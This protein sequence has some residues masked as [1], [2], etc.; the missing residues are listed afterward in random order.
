MLFASTTLNYMDRQSMSLVG[1][2]I[3][4]EFRIDNEGFGW[5]LAAFQLTYALFQVPAGYLADRWDVRK[6]YAV[7]VAWWSLA[8]IMVAF[9]STLAALL[10]FRVLLGIGE[11]FNWPCA[12]KVT[13]KVLPPESRSLGNGIFN[14]GAAIGAVITPLIV[15]PLASYFGWRTAFVVAGMLGFLWVLVWP[16]LVYRG[17]IGVFDETPR[18]PIL[19][20]QE[21]DISKLTPRAAGSFAMVGLLSILIAASG[22]RFGMV[23]LWWSIAFL[24]FGLLA[25]ARLLPSRD[26]EGRDW[27]RSIGEVVHLRRFW[28]LCV[29]ACSVNVSWH[30]LVNW[31][32][33]LFKTDLSMPYLIGGMAS[34]IP[35]VAA[36]LGNLGGGWFSRF[37]ARRGER[38]DRARAKVILM[39]CMFI[40]LALLAGRSSHPYL[41]IVILALVAFG[42]AAY[43]ANY[44]AFCQEVSGRHTGLVVGV[45]GAL[46]NLFAAGFLPIAGRIKDQ[47]GSFSS[48]FVVVGLLPLLGIVAVLLGWG[49]EIQGD[50]SEVQP[51]PS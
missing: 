40:V 33:T 32:A 41:T 16:F 36:D 17:P 3:R 47:T 27:A 23:A 43:M 19:S 44:F 48:V 26:L 6:V 22:L 1:E 24:M 25:T 15:P 12:L 14:S 46:G 20:D 51:Q 10:A 39:S 34:A 2:D 18:Q 30:F 9:S 28:V 35:F 49:W 31:M 42:T 7:A 50:D 8:A 29:M 37:L 5:V 11:S 38:S 45:L 21:L 13:S 4:S